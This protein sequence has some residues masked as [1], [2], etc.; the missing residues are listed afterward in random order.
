MTDIALKELDA[1]IRKRRKQV[2]QLRQELEDMEDYIDILEAR[3]KSL[4]KPRLTHAQVEKRYAV[5]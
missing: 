5:K 1:D 4:G 3:R 2:T